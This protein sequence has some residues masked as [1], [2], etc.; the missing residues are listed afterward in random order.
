M[1][2]LERKLK[3][4]GVDVRDKDGKFRSLS[5]IITEIAISNFFKT[6]DEDTKTKFCGILVGDRNKSTMERLLSER[7]LYT[8]KRK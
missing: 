1:N 8:S 6:A 5:E 2:D 7:S 3:D 4:I